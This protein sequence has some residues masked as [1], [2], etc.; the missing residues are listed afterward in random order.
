M[1]IIV[2]VLIVMTAGLSLGLGLLITALTTKY[3]DFTFLLS[4]AIQLGMYA[5]PIIYPS[6]SIESEKVKLAVMANPMSSIIETFRYAF[7][8]VGNFS[9]LAL[10]YSL[11]VMIV[12]ILI[13]ILTFNRVEKN[14]MD[15]V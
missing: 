7:L 12:L 2:P 10:G 11:L 14:F 15:T 9:W 13:G 3:R 4:F 8:G 5:T 6:N 1:I